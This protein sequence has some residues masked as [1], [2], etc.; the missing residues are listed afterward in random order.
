MAA[1]HLGE[2]REA[3]MN[4]AAPD[5]LRTQQE[6]MSLPRAAKPAEVART[7]IASAIS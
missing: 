4:I 1:Q 6:M 5:M 3:G 2:A 7:A